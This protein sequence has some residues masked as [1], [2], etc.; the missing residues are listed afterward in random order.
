MP[1]HQPGINFGMVLPTSFGLEQFL[2]MTKALKRVEDKYKK[3]KY[4]QQNRHNQS[5]GGNN[6]NKENQQPNDLMQLTSPPS[7]NQIT[8][9]TQIGNITVEQIAT[10]LGSDPD[11]MVEALEDVFT[12]QTMEE[13][14]TPLPESQ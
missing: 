12:P 4:H 8:R 6:P 13:Q 14:Y 9:N 1:D 11:H 7:Q 2:E 5:N 3:P 10:A